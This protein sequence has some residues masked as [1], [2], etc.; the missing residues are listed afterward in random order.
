[1]FL[2][3]NPA[4]TPKARELRKNM[5]PWERKLWYDFLRHHPVRFQRQKPIGNYIV[6]FYCASRKLA[7]ELDG[8][9]HYEEAGKTYD[10]QRT[11]E[12]S[13]L[14]IR[15]LRFSNLDIDTNFEGVC[16]MIQSAINDLCGEEFL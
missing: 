11:K 14:G 6:D 13:K 5:T 1:M 16:L 3:R 2:E 10:R 8:G 7:I 9:Q 15:I 4:L 12:L